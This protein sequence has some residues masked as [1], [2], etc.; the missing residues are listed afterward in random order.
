MGREHAKAVGNV[1]LGSV[2]AAVDP[3]EGARKSFEELVPGARTYATLDDLLA[4]EPDPPDVVHVCTAPAH[5]HAAVARRALEAGS[6]IYVEKPFTDD[7]ATATEILDLAEAR[8]LKV[9]CGY[10]LLF[11]DVAREAAEFVKSPGSTVHVESYFAFKPRRTGANVRLRISEEEQLLDILPHP[12]YLLL[13][14]LSQAHPEHAMELESLGMGDDGSVHALLRRGPVRGVLVVTLEARPVESTVEIV[15]S[16]GRMQVDFMRGTVQRLQGAG[17]SALQKVL[18][19]FR[20]AWQLTIGTTTALAARALG[21][22]GGYLGLERLIEEFYRSIR[23]DRPSPVSP[24]LIGDT[25]RIGD[26][27]RGALD[28]IDVAGP[29][30]VGPSRGGV[31]AVTGGTGFLGRRLARELVER[32]RR[33]RA[34]SRRRPPPWAAVPGVE[35]VEC[36]LGEAVP[37]SLFEGCDCVV[38]LAAATS[39]GYETHQRDSID[40]TRHVIQSAAE[41]RVGKVVYVSSLAVIDQQGGKEV[42]E[43]SPLLTGREAGPYAWGKA[44]AEV[45][46]ARVARERGVPLRI[47]RPGPIVDFERFDPPGR[48]G[49][50]VGSWYVAVGPASEKLYLVDVGFLARTLSWMTEHFEEVP[51][52]VHA[53]S[54][55]APTRREL[56]ARVRAANPGAR[57]IW[58]PRPA[59]FVLSGMA[60]ILQKVLRPRRAAVSLSKAFASTRYD[61]TRIESLAATIKRGSGRAVAAPGAVVASESRR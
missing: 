8:G 13:D 47:V 18:D 22:G 3:D 25:E 37:P 5:T 10:Q 56:V 14:L 23:E 21:K 59:L 28:R 1:P 38:H 46:G 42:D 30:G 51:E 35:Y 55:S 36:D 32:G 17:T 40:A 33:V 49:R 29:V 60:T 53:L 58:L 52:I 45:E 26:A 57:V 20:W 50:W 44:T 39:G 24:E 9:C 19:P 48:L 27:V 31:I 16:N 6:H 4:G 41:A 43:S 7:A 2:V 34:V 15:R 11:Q 54:P 61:T 12:T